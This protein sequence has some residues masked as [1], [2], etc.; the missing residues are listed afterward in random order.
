MAHMLYLQCKAGD[1]PK[2]TT[3]KQTN[4]LAYQA[5]GLYP[6]VEAYRVPQATEVMEMNH[7]DPTTDTT[8]R[9][10]DHDRL[11][12]FFEGLPNTYYAYVDAGDLGEHSYSYSFDSNLVSLLDTMDCVAPST[13][14]PT[15]NLPILQSLRSQAWRAFLWD[16]AKQLHWSNLQRERQFGLV[17]CILHMEKFGLKDNDPT[18]CKKFHLPDDEHAPCIDRVQ[19]YKE[20]KAKGQDLVQ[21]PSGWRDQF[22]HVFPQ[23]KQQLSTEPLWS[24]GKPQH[25]SRNLRS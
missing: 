13:P 9:V 3:F 7:H 4:P 1:G 15:P 8:I 12:P 2:S 25:F 17:H 19:Q 5:F 23:L 18:F 20:A 11:G 24:L 21:L 10:E 14:Q 22:N 6:N 16:E